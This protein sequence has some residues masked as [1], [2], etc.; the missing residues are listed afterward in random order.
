MS[1]GFDAPWASVIIPGEAPAGCDAWG[2]IRGE[3]CGTVDER[4]GDNFI[5]V[6]IYK[7]EEGFYYGFQLKVGTMIREQ[8]TNIHGEA[9]GTADTARAAAG[10][11]IEAL[12]GT[13]K[14]VKKLFV[15]FGKIRYNQGMLFEDGEV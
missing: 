12:C 14:N 10:R 11:E 15:D 8:A 6:L 5:R 2:N 7:R 3:P 9:F 1:D 4:H 13:N